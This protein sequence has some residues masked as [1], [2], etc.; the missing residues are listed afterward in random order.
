MSYIANA[1]TTWKT[2]GGEE[3][4]L[5]LTP[6]LTGP[7]AQQ[8][9]DQNSGGRVYTCFQPETFA[10]RASDLNV[11][12]DLVGA[13][14]QVFHLP[15]LHAKVLI[16]GD[17]LAS[18]GS[19]NMTVRGTKNRELTFIAYE[20]ALVERAH[21]KVALW[22][23]QA[24]PITL[25]MIEDMVAMLPELQ[26]LYD[27]FSAACEPALKMVER[28]L[29]L[30]KSACTD[31]RDKAQA[32]T[33]SRIVAALQAA[34]VSADYTRGIVKYR[35]ASDQTTLMCNYKSPLNWTIENRPQQ[36]TRLHRYLCVNESGRLG[37]ARVASTRISM[38]GTGI[39]FEPG[40]I[41]EKPEWRV[42][43]EAN[44]AF[45]DGCPH[46]ANLVV[47]VVCSGEQLCW[48]PLRFTLSECKT[49]SPRRHVDKED[50]PALGKAARTWITANKEAF[51]RSV[52]RGVTV[53]F[54]Y[55]SNLIGV[56]AEDFFG[57]RGTF[58]VLKVALVE[59]SPVLTARRGWF[60]PG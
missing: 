48:I 24:T 59:G 10:S 1:H 58:H 18:V 11:I 39:D 31:A 2:V 55:Q 8:L 51:E 21:R 33:R 27:Q 7:L 49:Y 57:A 14:H 29:A 32:E 56:D 4:L 25:K 41:K 23:D 54:Q 47:H 15:G 13:G 42:R 52:V 5:I 30:A 9:L 28:H 37:W 40:L 17:R 20:K 6:Y 34:P 46:G 16:A 22:L 35:P 53:S 38:I 19:Q 12:R 60:W 44:G 3:E 36:L 50:N 26:A 45:P 43:V